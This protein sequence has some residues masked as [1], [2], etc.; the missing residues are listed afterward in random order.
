MQQQ[1]NPAFRMNEQQTYNSKFERVE[2]LYQISPFGVVLQPVAPSVRPSIP[3]TLPESPII[4]PPT[5]PQIPTTPQ[6]TQNTKQEQAVSPQQQHPLTI[7]SPLSVGGF[8]YTPPPYP[9]LPLPPNAQFPSPAFLNAPLLT[10]NTKSAYVSSEIAARQEKLEKYR[11]KRAK[12][13]YNRPVDQ[14]KRERACARS[15]DQNGQFT[16]EN[17]REQE[18]MRQALEALEA[19]NKESELLKSQL[20]QVEREL[21]QLRRRAEEE[22]LAK[23]HML[24]Q[25]EA[26]QR[27]N[28]DLIHENT[29]LWSTVPIDQVF[30][31]INP[32][33]PP[34]F[35]DA[36]KQKI[37]FSTI[38]L[39][40]T[41]SPHL[42]AAR[43]EDMDFEQRWDDM[44]FFT[45]AQS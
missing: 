18:K 42:E 43:T 29:L 16:S 2:S 1:F 37:D 4:T 34:V 26:Q 21:E 20:S 5:S 9:G 8:L 6:P 11:E 22:R 15:R 24:K 41:D 17:K 39:N 3:I 33:N 44:T 38:E 27:M 23:Q 10:P 31:T 45:G 36:F 25:L 40:W 28:Q 12:R 30:N 14:G 7:L 32:T 35:L 13:N 19:S